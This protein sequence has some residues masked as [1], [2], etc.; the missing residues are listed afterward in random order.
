MTNSDSSGSKQFFSVR[1]SVVRTTHN[2]SDNVAD[3]TKF[4]GTT[5]FITYKCDVITTNK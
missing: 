3:T 2:M 1:D 4:I 5:K